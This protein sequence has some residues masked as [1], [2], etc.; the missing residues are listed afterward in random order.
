MSPRNHILFSLSIF[1]L[2]T[3]LSS[4][5]FGQGI[6]VVLSGGGSRGMAHIGVLKALEENGIPIDYILGTSIGAAIGG[7]YASGYSPEEIEVLF[8]NN[9]FNQWINNDFD[10]GKTYYYMKDAEDAGWIELKMDFKNRY[11]KILPPKVKNPAELDFELTRIFASASAAANYDFNQ[12]MIPFRCVTSDID[13]N[14][15]AILKRGNLANSI[16]ASITFPFLFK[17]IE[18]DGT[19][20]FD[21]GMYNNFPADVAIEAFNPALIIGSKVSG[22]YPKPDPDDVLS[23]IQNMLMV[24]TDFHLDSSKGILIEP[25]V[26]RVSLTDFSPYAEFIES[27][28]NETLIRLPEIISKIPGRRSK[29]DLKII[30]TNFNLKK[31]E[32]NIDSIFLDGLNSKEEKYVRKTLTHKSKNLSLSKVEPLYYKLVTDNQLVV[33]GLKMHYNQD[34]RKYD[35][36]LNLK[37]TNKLNIKFGGNISSHLANEA[38]VEINY[39]TLFQDALR[40]KFNVYFGR[41]YTSVLLGG[42]LDFPGRLPFY[43]GGKLVYNHYDYFKGNIHF[44]ED[45]TPSFLIENG[46]YFKAYGGI[47]TNITGKI[48]ADLTL[49]FNDDLYY[50][51]NIFSREDT[52]DRTK[53]GFIKTGLTWEMNSLNRKQYAS[54]GARFRIMAGFIGGEEEYISGSKSNEL[55][56]NPKTKHNQIFFDLLWDNYF[57]TLGPIKLGFFGHLHLSNQEF[58]SNYTSSLLSAP[59]FEPIPESKTLF[60]PNYRAYNYGAAGLKLVWRVSKRIDIRAES[61][62]FQPYQHIMKNDDNTAYFGNTLE[63]RYWIANGAVVYHTFFGPISVSLNY[64]D[65]PEESLFFSLNIGFLIFNQRALE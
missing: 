61:Y 50:Q 20:M 25:P 43:L 4:N 26:K 57:K 35:L 22:N 7:L 27:G 38:M 47:P 15:A 23:Q 40:L 39:H 48:E 34:K 51:N 44:I 32:Y 62:L 37:P 46:N 55:P 65:N 17:P 16:R 8:S 11:S 53:F 28:Y 18:I 59:A 60:L 52:A 64:F 2:I 42:R 1:I 29:D 14:R 31:Q 45:V 3:I 24:N 21:G 5:L 49:G 9:N 56:E 63:D 54:S 13:S 12:L 58:F 19:L 10:P 30:R 6:A 36:F 33:N 41:F